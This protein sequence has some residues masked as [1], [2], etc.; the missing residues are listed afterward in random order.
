MNEDK[1][2]TPDMIRG[3]H[4]GMPLMERNS[5]LGLQEYKMEMF[6]MLQQA[7]YEEGVPATEWETIGDLAFRI[8][9]L[10]GIG[11]DEFRIGD[12]TEVEVAMGVFKRFN[13]LVPN[14]GGEE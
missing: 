7:L 4:P 14:E 9:Y 6:T 1:V 2:V 8:G 11:Y 3:G 10:Y 5:Y 13:E 12:D